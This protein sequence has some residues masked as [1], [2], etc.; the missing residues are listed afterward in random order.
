MFY[1][2]TVFC[3]K[4]FCDVKMYVSWGYSLICINICIKFSISLLMF[5]IISDFCGV[6]GAVYRRDVPVPAGPA[7]AAHGRAAP[8]PHYGGQ[9]YASRYLAANCWQVYIT[10]LYFIISLLDEQSLKRV[11]ILSHVDTG[12]FYK[13][14]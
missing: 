9:R 8:R 10:D 13:N 1:V 14:R 7:A 4:L 5:L 11:D 6:G 3:G 12:L 2:G